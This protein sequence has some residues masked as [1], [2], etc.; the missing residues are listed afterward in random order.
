MVFFFA[1]PLGQM[2]FRSFTDPATGLDNYARFAQTPSGVRSLLETLAMSAAVTLTCAVVGYVFSS[3]P[4]AYSA[5]LKRNFVDSSSKLSFHLQ[6]LQAD[7]LLTKGDRGHYRVTEA[8]QRA[9][10]VVRALSE[11]KH[12][13]LLISKS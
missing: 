3:G 2:I 8:G 12:G 13:T 6:K 4:V 7:G 10:H 5:I 1:W 9:W 11:R